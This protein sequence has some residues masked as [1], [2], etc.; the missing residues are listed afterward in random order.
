MVDKLVT[1]TKIHFNK[2]SNML[3]IIIQKYQKEISFMWKRRYF[4]KIIFEIKNCMKSE[5]WSDMFVKILPNLLKLCLVLV[6]KP[7]HG[8]ALIWKYVILA[9]L[10][11]FF[12]HFCNLH[13]LNIDSCSLLFLI[14]PNIFYILILFG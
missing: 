13:Y 5:F 9:L 8:F 11:H 7:L 14:L 6:T 2:N 4:Y 12:A 1:Q 10:C 3:K